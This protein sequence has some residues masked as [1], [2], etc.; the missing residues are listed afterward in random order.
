VPPRDPHVRVTTSP[1]VS[2][3]LIV[4]PLNR[5]PDGGARDRSTA[6]PELLKPRSLERQHR[7]R[8]KHVRPGGVPD[9]TTRAA[10]SS[11]RTSLEG[12]VRGNGWLQPPAAS[13]RHSAP[14]PRA[15]NSYGL[16]TLPNE[17]DASLQYRSGGRTWDRSGGPAA[18]PRALSA[19]D[20]PT[21]ARSA[22]DRVARRPRVL[23]V[24]AARARG[25][26]TPDRRRVRVGPP[27]RQ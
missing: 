22:R 13:M 8:T 21:L 10:Q 26:R 1:A 16:S 25:T 11:I 19:E 9:T 3:V 18:P 5:E 20:G 12:G 15:R 6:L 14:C 17:S 27:S 2:R 23:P 4:A 24:D 7:R